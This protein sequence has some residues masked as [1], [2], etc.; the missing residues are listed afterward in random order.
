MILGL[1]YPKSAGL[2]LVMGDS[3]RLKHG[4]S[5]IIHN[6]P[7]ALLFCGDHFMIFSKFDAVDEVNEVRLGL[8]C[9]DSISVTDPD[10]PIIP[11]V[12][13]CLLG[14]MHHAAVQPSKVQVPSSR[15]S[16]AP[17]TNPGRVTTR[18]GTQNILASNTEEGQSKCVLDVIFSATYASVLFSIS[19][20]IPSIAITFDVGLKFE[21]T[22]S[23]LHRISL[24]PTTPPPPTW[25]PSVEIS[26]QS[27]SPYSDFSP[28][29]WPL[30]SRPPSL[31]EILLDKII[32]PGEGVQVFPGKIKDNKQ[33]VIAK[34]VP[35]QYPR[36]GELLTEVPA[37][38]ALISFHG[39]AIP[40][41]YGLFCCHRFVVLLMEDSSGISLAVYGGA[42]A[43]NS[44]QR[45]ISRLLAMHVGLMTDKQR[46]LVFM[47]AKYPRGRGGSW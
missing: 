14:V 20:Q 16:G 21:I 42:S 27:D 34:I 11:I 28:E 5:M 43:L 4:V 38:A 26:G 33:R 35:A 19:F 7:W 12:V 31:C 24:G 17:V 29:D 47:L 3:F 15:R 37:Y 22:T 36:I 10:F 45:C 18:K 23:Y 6:A 9:S 2:S 44:S 41:I 46:R 1:S 39:T 13:F 8:A 32:V 30:Q 40:I 25:V